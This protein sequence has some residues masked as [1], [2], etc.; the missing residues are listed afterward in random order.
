MRVAL[1]ARYTAAH[2]ANDVLLLKNSIAQ[3][4]K[5]NE[6]CISNQMLV[7][8]GQTAIP[9]M[10]DLMSLECGILF[11]S[12][13]SWHV[14]TLC[15]LLLTYL[16][17]TAPHMPSQ[18]T[19]NDEVA[20]VPVSSSRRFINMFFVEDEI[21]LNETVVSARLPYDR[22]NIIGAEPF[23]FLSNDVVRGARSKCHQF[24]TP[25]PI[26]M[27]RKLSS[28]ADLSRF[29]LY[30]VCFIVI[31]RGYSGTFLSPIFSSSYQQRHSCRLDME[32]LYGGGGRERER[33]QTFYF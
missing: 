23:T 29:F 17:F 16:F 24:H 15:L 19:W 4:P 13:S 12:L 5:H 25:F 32:F 9:R 26:P 33:C 1:L 10:G 30:G 21:P 11:S 31:L 14:A 8:R 20:S 3:I 2:A 28:S 18:V 6:K 27:S 22:V 7:S